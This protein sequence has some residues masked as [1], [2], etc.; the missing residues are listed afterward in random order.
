M[1]GSL[2]FVSGASGADKTTLI[3]HALERLPNLVYLK[4]VTTRPQRPDE[5]N[6]PEYEFVTNFQY[7]KRRLSSRN[8]DHADYNGFK[9]G[10]DVDAIR[11]QLRSGVNVICSVMPDLQIIDTMRRRY[12]T[13]PLT[14][15]IDAP[16]EVAM[17]R[18][19]DNLLRL[20][21]E[22]DDAV[23]A[24]FGKIFTPTGDL[25]KDKAAFVK[26]LKPLLA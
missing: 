19:Q 2:I 4:T 7:E 17:E 13:V 3:R 26:L 12:K 1:I 18:T 20:D 5:A 25:K 8:W 6:K 11:R 16:H 23:K 15:W 10:T 21:R 22:E 14:I 24:S 9:Y